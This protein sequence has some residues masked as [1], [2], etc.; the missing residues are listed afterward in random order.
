MITKRNF[1]FLLLL[2]TAFLLTL[3]TV[4]PASAAPIVQATDLRCDYRTDPL[5]IGG[6]PPRLSWIL[7]LDKR[8]E[9][10]TAYHVLVSTSPEALE[11]EHGDLWDSGKV[12][13]D[14]SIQQEYR[15]KTLM[16][17][18]HC[19]WKVRVWDMNGKPSAWSKPASWS[20]GLLKQE[21]WQARWIGYDAAYHPDETVVRNNALFTTQGLR[22]VRFPSGDA[23][24]IA[25]A[26][27]FRKRFEIPADRK[28]TRA[29]FTL[30][31]DNQCGAAVN[32]V[33]LGQAAR[34]EKAARLDA[35]SALHAGANVASL[36]VTNTDAMPAAVVGKL[37]VQFDTGADMVLPLD[38]SWKA[39]RQ[40]SGNWQAESFDDQ[41]WP[42]AE[43]FDGMPWHGPP[44]LADIPRMPAPFLRKTFSVSK[45]IRRA[46]AY[47]TALG[48][49]ELHLNGKRVGQDIFTPGW[50]EYRKRVAH[51]TYDVTGLIQQGDN[52]VG[53]ILGD[54]WYAGL[55]AHLG[56]RNFYGGPPR[57]LLQILIEH[58]DGSTQT[59]TSDGSWKASFGPIRHAD[60]LLG[61]EYDARLVLAG[62]D[63]AAFNDNAWSPVVE[64]ASLFS[65]PKPGTQVE[66]AVTEP[67]RRLEQL[68]TVKLTEPR[69]GCY[70][71]DLGQNMVGWVRLKVRGIAGQRITVR[72][73]EMLNPDGTIY[74]AGLRSATATDF[75]TLADSQEATLEPY[76]TF[77]GFRY[78]EVSGLTTKP[79]AGMVTGIVVHSDMRR[80]GE[81]ACSSPLVNRL[82]QNIIWGQ[83]GNHLEIPTDCPQ[84][85][86][87]SCSLFFLM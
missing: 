3:S 78:V 5:G 56:R 36:S 27:Y 7:P 50:T 73:G 4:L 63:A 52:C 8:G 74:T 34:W 1:S 77:H 61:C 13:S 30:Y 16:S 64:G 33:V 57:L 49:Y 17:G 55:L 26:A 39:A 80:T 82:Y 45:P 76:F 72:H 31:A 71:F 35:G 68:H 60:L 20:M 81:F 65:S 87:A 58:S 12:P 54:G 32:G 59:I 23:K 86:T 40:A 42:A 66:P 79:D 28:V 70:T 21:D 85:L 6:A 2:L 83:K 43:P 37:V 75:Y 25:V 84:R 47:V 51:Q 53:G 15:G 24:P 67:S 44:S 41:A 38:G 11:Q 10:Q 46:T 48:L 69:P 19:Y 14:Q 18:M 22:W 62:W 9:R 29:V